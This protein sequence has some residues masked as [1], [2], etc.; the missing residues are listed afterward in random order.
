[1]ATRTESDSMGPIEVDDDPLL[2]RADR[3]ARSQNFTIGG[4]QHAAPS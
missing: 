2:G 3:S 1:M 4:E